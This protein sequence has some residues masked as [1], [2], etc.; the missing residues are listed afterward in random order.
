MK[1]ADQDSYFAKLKIAVET[2][3]D[4]D[5]GQSINSSSRYYNAWKTKTLKGKDLEEFMKKNFG[6]D[7]PLG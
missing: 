4:P 1:K 7:Y 5:T 2:G 3:I 6:V